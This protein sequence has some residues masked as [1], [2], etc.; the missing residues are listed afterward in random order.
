MTIGMDC[1]REAEWLKWLWQ[2]IVWSWAWYLAHHYSFGVQN[3][4][5]TRCVLIV[6][7]L[8][9]S[10]SIEDVSYEEDS[11][12]WIGPRLVSFFSNITLW[13]SILFCISSVHRFDAI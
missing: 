13:S 5:M 10:L 1:L 2:E 12:I 4:A 7:V 6:K 11:N 3:V 9:S 8:T